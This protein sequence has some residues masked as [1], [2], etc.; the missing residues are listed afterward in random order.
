MNFKIEDT[1]WASGVGA[2][3]LSFL[4][5]LFTAFSLAGSNIFI[6]NFLLLLVAI[7]AILSGVALLLAA[8]EVYMKLYRTPE[9]KL[10]RIAQRLYRGAMGEELDVAKA[11]Q[12]LEAVQAH[13]KTVALPAIQMMKTEPE[14]NGPIAPAVPDPYAP[15]TPEQIIATSYI[16][17]NIVK[18]QREG[19]QVPS[20]PSNKPT[21]HSFVDTQPINIPVELMKI[22]APAKPAEKP[23][24]IHGLENK[25][26]LPST[27]IDAIVTIGTDGLM[28]QS[29]EFKSL[30]ENA[31]AKATVDASYRL[32]LRG[33]T[34]GIGAR[35]TK[36]T[37]NGVD[38][39]AF[40]LK[41]I[42]KI[43]AKSLL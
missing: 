13:P 39:T 35:G 10:S 17:D 14:D 38:F 7:G 12:V 41:D 42:E 28:P 20:Q 25:K 6:I 29:D 2:S 33:K 24:A 1:A 23:K 31:V 30:L 21:V 32:K 4:I 34:Y 11:Y 16:I 37:E 27:D 43:Q 36:M 3:I 18:N 22:K 5:G 8:T 9:R 26:V 19:I 40:S 15:M